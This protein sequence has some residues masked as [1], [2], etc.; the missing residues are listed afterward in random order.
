MN[1]SET[2]LL[3]DWRF[4]RG[5]PQGAEAPSFDDGAWQRVSIPHDWAIDG[6]FD[7]TIDMQ[8]V[9]IT[10]NQEKVATEKTGRTGSLPW[11][12]VG[13]YRREIELPAGCTYAELVFDGAM[14][15]SRIFLD[16]E[17]IGGRPYGYV[18]F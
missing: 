16:G 10:E 8:T 4:T 1:T 12:G 14:A 3:D 2:L 11:I 7:K 9:A 18:T 17:E 5:D 15:N 6:P 13:W